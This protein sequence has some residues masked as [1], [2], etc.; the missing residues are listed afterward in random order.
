MLLCILGTRDHRDNGLSTRIEAFE[1]LGI[2]AEV[3]VAREEMA[4]SRAF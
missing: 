4:N 3:T 2:L 1:R